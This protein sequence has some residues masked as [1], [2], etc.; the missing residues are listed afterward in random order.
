MNEKYYIFSELE[1]IEEIGVLIPG[2]IKNVSFWSAQKLLLKGKLPKYIYILYF[3]NFILNQLNNFNIIV[4]E[5]G[6]NILHYSILQFRRNQ[7]KEIILEKNSIEIGPSFTYPEFRNLKIYTTVIN[8]IIRSHKNTFSIVRKSNL[9]S[10]SVFK[11]FK[12][13]I[14]PI[15]KLKKFEISFYHLEK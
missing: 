7:Y 5:N 4:F 1:E 2:N 14:Y 11:K 12:P 10:I 13:K 15:Y 9:N 3:K 6:H 8:H